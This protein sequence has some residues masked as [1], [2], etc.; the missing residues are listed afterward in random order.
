MKRIYLS[1]VLV[2]TVLS[3]FSQASVSYYKGEWTEVNKHTLF[4]GI[5][6]ISID[7]N[8]ET[9]AELVWTYLAIDSANREMMIMYQGKKGR[10]GIEYA[11]GSFSETT[12]DLEFEGKRTDDPSLI[13]GLDKYHLKL[14]AN[15]QV[16]YGKTETQGTNEGLMYAVKMDNKKGEKE[17]NEAKARVR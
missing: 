14:A 9:K 4:T 15:K 5:F 2:L 10:T 7:P 1:L 3:A 13:L 16:I 12:N 17:F 6:K 11:E 8:G